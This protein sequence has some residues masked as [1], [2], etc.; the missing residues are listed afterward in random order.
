MFTV[1]L[2]VIINTL[3]GSGSF[4]KTTEYVGVEKSYE[5]C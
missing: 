5:T 2:V 4:S 1:D 3:N